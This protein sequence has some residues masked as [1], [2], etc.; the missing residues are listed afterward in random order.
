[1]L[2]LDRPSGPRPVDHRAVAGFPQPEAEAQAGPHHDRVVQLVEVPFAEEQ[3]MDRLGASLT[4]CPDARDQHI[5][6]IGADDAGHADQDRQQLDPE[7]YV[8]RRLDGVVA[9]QHEQRVA[10]EIGPR[11]DRAS[12]PLISHHAGEDG[13]DGQHHQGSEHDPGRF[14]HMGH[15]LGLGTRLAVEGHED[16]PE[17]VERGHGRRRDAEPEGEFA[18]PAVIGEADSRIRSLELK[19][20]KPIRVPGMPMPARAR[21]PTTISQ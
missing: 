14:M 11:L 9:R 4:R 2:T 5:G 13:A 1:M 20:A 15:D 16:H 8:M 17:A 19:P 18:E 7:R 6:Q 21:L 10:P 3:R 12:E